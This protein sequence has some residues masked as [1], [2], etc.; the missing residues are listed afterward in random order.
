MAISTPPTRL[1]RSLRRRSGLLLLLL[2]WRRGLPPKE[3]PPKS[4]A[5]R[6]K[7]WRP[8]VSLPLLVVLVLLW[9]LQG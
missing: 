1:H 8:Q 9:S 6:N 2:R 5:P 7:K 3:R 4:R